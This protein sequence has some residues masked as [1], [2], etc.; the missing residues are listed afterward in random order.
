V[1]LPAAREESAIMQGLATKGPHIEDC[2]TPYFTTSRQLPCAPEVRLDEQPF[3]LPQQNS[4]WP[5]QEQI[6][7][8]KKSCDFRIFLKKQFV[9]KNRQFLVMAMSG[10]IQIDCFPYKP[11]CGDYI[12]LEPP[13]NLIERHICSEG[14]YINQGG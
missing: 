6:T 9:Y 8:N 11:V 10:I 12:N 2:G 3:L 1:L 4:E 5:S 7:R 14:V 13:E